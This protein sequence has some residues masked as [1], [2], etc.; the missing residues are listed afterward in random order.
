M[1]AIGDNSAKKLRLRFPNGFEFEALGSE[2][3][4]KEQLQSFLGQE[5]NLSSTAPPQTKTESGGSPGNKNNSNGDN[6]IGIQWEKIAEKA[7]NDLLLR[8]KLEN[9][10]QAAEACLILMAA[11]KDM[12]N[13]PR[14]SALELARWLRKSGYPIARIDRILQNAVKNGDILVS[15]SR[16]GRKYELSP[17]GRLKAFLIAEKLS[18]RI[19]G[20]QPLEP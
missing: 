6:P 18:Q 10:G 20:A 13:Q 11:S 1:S 3:F 16:R 4:I 15:G 17:S 8:N 2:E 12:A 7:Q 14:P 19:T 9:L 5:K